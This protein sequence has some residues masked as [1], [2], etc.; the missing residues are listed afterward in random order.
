MLD[1]GAFIAIEGARGHV[2]KLLARLLRAGVPLVTSGGVVAQVWR[3][4]A[5]RQVPLAMLLPQIEVIALGGV[6]ARLVGM[7]L[8]V[9]RTRDAIDAHV[10]L[11]ARER[12]W[13]IL[14]FDA[15]DLR[16]IDPSVEIVV[17]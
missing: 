16:A 13:P 14:T 3:G 6:E 15:G 5:G 12:A 10:V 11:L 4:G 1:A 9:S 8:G 7:V 2:T 17:A